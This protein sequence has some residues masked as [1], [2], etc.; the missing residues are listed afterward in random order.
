M[1]AIL[2]LHTPAPREG[3]DS[4]RE[5]ELYDPAYP[6]FRAHFV[7]VWRKL[8]AEFKG[9][10]PKCVAFELLNEPH[11]G[12]P[13]ATGWNKL[14]DEVLTAVRE[15]PE[16]IV[17]IPAM[18][19]QDYNYIKYARVAGEDSNAVVSF[20][21][22]LPML[23]SHYKMLAWVGY[24]G[25]V[26]YPGWSF[27]LSRMLTNTRSMPLFTKRP[28]MPTGLWVKCPMRR[29]TVGMPD[30]RYIAANSDAVKTSR[31]RCVWRG[32]RIWWLPWRQII[33]HG[34]FGS[35]ST[36]D[37]DLS[38]WNMAFTGSTVLC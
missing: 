12:T 20:H 5:E 8:A 25:A 21:Y 30:L 27:P 22:Y 23:L 33:F 38:I 10:N 7:H 29:P 1:Y 31:K 24:Q 13:D 19:W 15:H 14:Q 35:A 2:D 16:R 3:S 37:S 34:R 6:E 26:Q 28:T 17:F 32:S 18:G 4:Y 36:A 9:H 11:D